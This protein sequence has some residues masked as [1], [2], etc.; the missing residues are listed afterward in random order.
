MGLLKQKEMSDTW[1]KC[2]KKMQSK[3]NLMIQTQNPIQETVP[4]VYLDIL[5]GEKELEE[6]YGEEV[7]KVAIYGGLEVSDNV[8]KFLRLPASVRLFNKIDKIVAEK[9]VEESATIDRWEVMSREGENRE[10]RLTPEEMRR[11]R[12]REFL[13]RKPCNKDRINLS[14]L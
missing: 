6:R 5:I 8:I 13:E 4:D 2:K 12:D 9:K 1:I 14:K 10:E 3:I 7:P 11:K